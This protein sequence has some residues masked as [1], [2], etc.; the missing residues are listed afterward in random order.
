MVLGEVEV[1]RRVLDGR[2]EDVREVLPLRHA[3]LEGAAA[4]H[5]APEH[6]VDLPLGDRLD[7]VV[8][9]RRVVLVVG[10]DHD[11]DVGPARERRRVA[12]LLVPAVSPVLRVD[13]DL[14]PLDRPGERHGPVAGGVV[15]EEDVVDA[16][17]RDLLE[18]PEQGLLGVVGGHD[19]RDPLPMAHDPGIMTTVSSGPRTR[20]VTGLFALLALLVVPVFPHFVSP[21]EMSRWAAARLARR[22]RGRLEVAADVAELLGPRIE[23]VAEVDGRLYPN[24]APGR[25][26]RPCPATSRPGPSRVPRRPARCAPP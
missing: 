8:E 24:K 19:D 6:R 18:A 4:E 2:E 5:P 15:D 12:G 17:L 1:E 21:N 3:A 10:V 26:S 16:L 23:D 7:Q 20:V 25:R 14:E 13:D 9:D 11:D 22:G